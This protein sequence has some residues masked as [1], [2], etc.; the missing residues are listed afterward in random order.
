MAEAEGAAKV[1]RK[2]RRTW[3][4]AAIGVGFLLLVVA[5]GETAPDSDAKVEAATA[6][7]TE[8][9]RH[10]GRQFYSAI[11]G[12]AAPC[13]AANKQLAA[14]ADAPTTP[15]AGY[16]AARAAHDIC[17]ASWSVFGDMDV[18]AQL[19]G[20]AEDAAA[21]AIDTCKLAY[22]S[23]MQ[24]AEKAM[25]IFDGDTR[26]STIESMREEA[27]AGN[28]GMYACVGQAMAAAVAA[29]VSLDDLGGDADAAE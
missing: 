13:D 18:P 3:G 6:E 26:P 14:F 17:Q 16:R 23:K 27:E 19:T 20:A 29:G 10:A 8:E 1:E 12:A 9:A 28:S 21:K 22:F 11:M 25:E 5:I 4:C 15:L 24:M 2:K 7:P